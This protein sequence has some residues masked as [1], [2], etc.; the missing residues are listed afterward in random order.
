MAA[1]IG[2]LQEICLPLSEIF[3]VTR[4]M[5]S[6][7]QFLIAAPTSGSGKTTISHGLISLLVSKGYK[8]QPFKC[9][10]DYIDTK[11]HKQSCG[12]PSYN[13]DSFMASESHLHTLYSQYASK[14]D[15]CIVEGMMGLFDGYDRYKGSS[16]EIA[17]ILNIPIVLVIRADSSAYSAAV[18]AKGFIDFDPNIKVAGV[19]FN[20]VGS[21][22]HVN[23]LKEACADLG[24][25]CFG[26][27]KKNSELVYAAQYLGLRFKS[28][29]Q[30]Q[31]HAKSAR[32]IC[33]EALDIDLLLQQT[34]RPV[35]KEK[36][37][38]RSKGE[39]NIW[40]AHNKESFSFM[41]AE[42]LDILRSMGKV[43]FFDPENR[44]IELA[45]NVDL[46]YLPGGY[47][48]HHV[49]NLMKAE[50]ILQSIRN[51][52]ENG[53]RTL[54]ECGGMMYLATSLIS[55]N[56]GEL[57]SHVAGVLPI[58]ISNKIEE[59][60]LS[61]GYRQFKLGEQELRG[62]EFHYTRMI[63]CDPDFHSIAQVYNA[64]GQPVDT[65]VFRYK[66]VIASY[67]HLYWGEVDVM[68]L[69]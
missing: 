23:M 61:L 34:T 27:I 5:K 29:K 41:Y 35:H 19:I 15:A 50:K 63:S 54:A 12:N 28:K 40:V 26:C 58:V 38:P 25:T 59:R 21:D 8:V 62:H 57:T 2:L 14:A 51:Y 32:D 64:K 39:L 4:I 43:T 3:F 22:R 6:I 52:I 69:F 24:I 56:R 45:S 66:N 9:G 13:L 60:G 16:A 44:E 65:P 36:L 31:Q 7:P 30:I 68:S 47:P 33:E 18:L 67:T 17:K 1:K 11:F 48:E 37:P 55:D 10:P 49:A 42:H 46:L 53:G 20:Y